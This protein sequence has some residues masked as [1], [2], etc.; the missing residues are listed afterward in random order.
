MLLH[1]IATLSKAKIVIKCTPI[2]MSFTRE[3]L[4][5][6]CCANDTE[7]RS[8]LSGGYGNSIIRN[9][10]SV[11]FFTSLFLKARDAEERERWIRA[12][13]DTIKRHSQTRKVML[14]LLMTE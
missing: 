2:K 5:Q 11:N 6:C 7:Y 9:P 13:E 4:C 12:L 3:I 1:L 14:M 10:I 8:I